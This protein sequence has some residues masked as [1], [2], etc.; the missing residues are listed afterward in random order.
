MRRHGLSLMEVIL[1]TALLLAATATVGRLAYITT[2]NAQR[3]EDRA[4]A[5][6]I[7]DFQIQ[8]LLL[9]QYPVKTKS[10]GPVIL[11]NVGTTS[12]QLAVSDRG[13]THPWLEW[14]VAIQVEPT[15]VPYLFQVQVDV[16]RM[17]EASETTVPDPTTRASLDANANSVL[18]T[19]SVVRLVRVNP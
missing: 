2:Q 11:S 13:L 7:A 10:R 8:Q 18:F 3:A 1:A 9:G 19:Y 5:A 4:I 17:R 15:A 6:Q 14:Q 12:E 16:F